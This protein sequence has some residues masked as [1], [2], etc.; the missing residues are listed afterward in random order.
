VHFAPLSRVPGVQL[1][2]IQ[3]GELGTRQ[4]Q[5][6]RGGFSVTELGPNFDEKSGAFEDTAAVMR[7]LDLVICSDSSIVHLAGGLGVPVWLALPIAVDWRWLRVRDDSPWY[8]TMR[9]FRQANFGDWPEVFERMAGLLTKRLMGTNAEEIVGNHRQEQDRQEK[10][11]LETLKKSKPEAAIR[12]YRHAL[13]LRADRAEDHNNLGVALAKHNKLEEARVCFQKAC[14]IQ[15]SFADAFNN[16]GLSELSLGQLTGAED[17]FRKA[18]RQRPKQHEFVNNLGVALQRQG[19]IK[20]ALAEFERALHL[21]PEYA[22]AH[23]NRGRTRLLMGDLEQ[24]FAELEWRLKIPGAGRPL[25]GHTWQGEPIAGQTLIIHA[26]GRLED[27]ILCMRYCGHAQAMGIPVALEFPRAWRWLETGFRGAKPLIALKSISKA[28]AY[29]TRLLSMPALC[30]TTSKAM[31]PGSPYLAADPERTQEWR[32]KLN[33]YPG[34]R[35]GIVRVGENVPIK[36]AAQEPLDLLVVQPKVEGITFLHLNPWSP[37]Q[38]P[39]GAWPGE[40]NQGDSTLIKL[41]EDPWPELAAVMTNLDLVITSESAAAHLA[42]ALSIPCWV[43]LT[44]A[45]D[46]CWMRDRSDSPWYSGVRLFRQL[47]TGDWAPAVQAVQAAVS[48]FASHDHPDGCL[49]IPVAPGELIDKI[50]ILELKNA[51]LDNPSQ[52]QNVRRELALLQA[53]RDRFLGPSDELLHTTRELAAVNSELWDIEDELRR[54]EARQYFGPRFVS[55]ARSVY[56]CNDRRAALKRQ[57]NDLLGAEI[58]EEKSYAS[59]GSLANASRSVPDGIDS[60]MIREE[61]S[62]N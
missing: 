5:E 51:R 43:F 39:L 34:R 41:G 12:L 24:G 8:P 49:M 45:P 18:T 44:R 16:R 52:L 54:C 47:E 4:I 46:W 31:P 28:D 10:L 42:G 13:K 20:P 50:T 59:D 62:D 6:N 7:C 9:L 56:G 11:R 40:P 53:A 57:I 23:V 17:S 60:S 3:K 35:V 32:R 29:H 30:H 14:R 48:R 15:P 25:P 38:G 27:A 22:E 21:K 36:N 58:R 26:D 33:S 55:L 61:L 1:I 19:K 37:D 2:S